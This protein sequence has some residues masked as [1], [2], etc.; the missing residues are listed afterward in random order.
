M[1]DR[2]AA[3]AWDRLRPELAR[4][5]VPPILFPPLY[6][7]IHAPAARRD[8]ALRTAAAAL[9]PDGHA[10]RVLAA[11]AT[12]DRREVRRLALELASRL[13]PLDAATVERLRPLLRDRHIPAAVRLAA[14]VALTRTTGPDGPAT[15]QVLRDFA[16]G[17][18]KSHALDRAAALR[19][20]F[21][22]LPAFEPFLAYLRRKVKLRCP[23]CRAHLPRTEMVRHV[24]ERHGGLLVHRRLTSPWRLIDAWGAARDEPP[25]AARGLFRLHRWMLRQGIGGDEARDHLRREAV[26]QKGSLCPECLAVVPLPPERFPAADDVRPLPVSHG[27]LAG[28]GYGVEVTEGGLYPRL[29]IETPRDVLFNG[30][31]PGG[32][33]T[34]RAALALGVGPWVALAVVTAVLAPPKLALLLTTLVLIGAFAMRHAVKR[35]HR[36]PADPRDRAVYHSWTKLA[37]YLHAAGVDAGAA[38][39]LARL[40]LTSL[41]RGQPKVRQ[42]ILGQLVEFTAGEVRA[43]RGRPADL[44]A[45]VRLQAADAARTGGDPVACIATVVGPCLAGEAPLALADLALADELLDDWTAGRRA[46]LRVLLAARAFEA[47]LEV[48][49]LFDLGRAAPRLGRVLGVGDPDGLARLRLLWSLRPT[50]PWHACGPAATVFELANYPMLGSQHLEAAPDLLLYQPLVAEGE[51]GPPAPLLVCGRGLLY[52]DALAHSADTP[53]SAQ[54]TWTGHDELVIGR[55]RLPF[56]TNPEALAGKLK[57]WSAYYF[58]EFLPQSELA[59]RRRS[60]AAAEWVRPLTVT[61]PKC[62][63]A[64]YGRRGRSGYG[65]TRTNG[66][67]DDQDAIQPTRI[68]SA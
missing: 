59:L 19:Q 49:D 33:L 30:R 45:L 55:H 17:V 21:G 23:R 10:G 41:G 40:A 32:R 13:P 36:P 12:S 8:A 58:Q 63:T 66:A 25:D 64:F 26:R 28:D 51:P 3:I 6:E 39:F 43:G 4:A 22:H 52:R 35:S 9:Q 53:I 29:R 34:L 60:D 65:A 11:L 42:A 57:R 1:P 67:M 68:G 14:A 20:R 2:D 18:G 27:R 61:C 50:R 37:P 7:V 16:A 31:E 38:A 44:A 54:E 48:Q 5:G 46:R 24:W 56:R 47:G 15:L 62:R